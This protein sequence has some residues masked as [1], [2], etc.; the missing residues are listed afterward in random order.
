VESIQAEGRNTA[1]AYQLLRVVQQ[2]VLQPYGFKGQEVHLLPLVP[3]IVTAMHLQQKLLVIDPPEGKYCCRQLVLQPSGLHHN[4]EVQDYYLTHNGIPKPLHPHLS[5]PDPLIPPQAIS[6]FA[7]SPQTPLHAPNPYCGLNPVSTGLLDL[8]RRD[9]LLAFLSQELLPFA[10]AAGA[11]QGTSRL[12][13]AAVGT[14]IMAGA[15]ALT[16]AR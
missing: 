6:L 3:D 15:R 5:L 7:T 13:A 8:G 10:P 4:C 12:A 14:G 9:L 11:G 2:T 1:P 16:Q